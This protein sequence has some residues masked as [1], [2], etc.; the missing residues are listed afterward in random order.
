M[1]KLVSLLLKTL[2]LALMV[3]SW[4]MVK[5]DPEKLIQFS[6][7]NQQFKTLLLMNKYTKEFKIKKT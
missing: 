7:V 6:V 5:L 4:P 3:L 2:L 1:N